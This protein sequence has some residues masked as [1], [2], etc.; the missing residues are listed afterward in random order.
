MIGWV[1][2]VQKN[3]FAMPDS[4]VG[5]NTE[6]RKLRVAIVGGGPSGLSS[7][8]ALRKWESQVE[9]TIFEKNTYWGGKCATVFSDGTLCNGV[10]G[11]YELG[12]GVV[13]KGSKSNADLEMLLKRHHI[14]YS[15]AAEKG[16][17]KY[18]FY[19][20]G[21]RFGLKSLLVTMLKHP[22]KATGAV[23][24]FAR[25]WQDLGRYSLDPA[26]D[27]F[28]KSAKLNKR[29]SDVYPQAFNI[30]CGFGM[31]G[32]GYA[33]LPDKGLTP[34]LMYYHQYAPK[35]VLVNPV[36]TID[37]GMQGIWST[38]AST[39]ESEITHLNE[40]V[41]HISRTD[42]EVEVQTSVGSYLFDY[43]IVAVP[44][45]PNLDFM[46]FT[47]KECNLLSKVHTNHYVTVL[48]EVEG[49]EDI[50]NVLVE[51]TVDNGKLG[52]VVFAYKRYANSDWVTI[53][54]YV[55][56]NETVSDQDI[57]DSVRNDLETEFGAKMKKFDNARIYHWN[58]YFPHLDTSDLDDSW[59]KKFEE[60]MQN[61]KRTLFVSSG[62]H[63]ETVGASVQYATKKVEDV[64]PKWLAG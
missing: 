48:C 10:P 58:D 23:F 8:E 24:S 42:H 30:C 41:I 1:T 62:L 44:L 25:Y 52:H 55:N 46:D 50:G 17:L 40:A 51:N 18:R 22:M 12:A 21:E 2:V 45:G 33:H 14:P 37:I 53:N 60:E 38:V 7:A 16:R 34:P 54:L 28:D 36:Y 49:L 29:F 57:L 6:E 31:Q 9:L 13:S 5:R 11:G 26:I 43:L 56:P 15:N 27:L 35:D 59:Y 64:V 4:V 20:K 61:R 3:L 19:S 47:E 39:Y 63:M 32:F